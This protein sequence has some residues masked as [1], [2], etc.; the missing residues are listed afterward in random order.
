MDRLTSASADSPGS[1]YSF[2][3]FRL[4][5]DGR[6]LRGETPVDL[7]PKELAALR[8]LL[9]HAGQIVTYS[10]LRKA[11]W[12]DTHVAADTISECVTSLCARLQP[13]ECI[14]T[15]YKRGY[16]FS[17]AVWPHS[18]GLSGALPRLAIMPFATEFDAP[19]YLGAAVAE[20]TAARLNEAQPPIASVAAQDS[21]STLARRG[22][23]A[24]QIGQ[25]LD[26]DLVLTGSLRP[27]P[28][29]YRL[30][31]ET[32]RAR[33]GVQ[34]WLEDLFVER[35]RVAGLEEE[36]ASSLA[37]HLLHRGL[38]ISAAGAAPAGNH[39]NTPYQRQA[40]ELYQRAHSEWQTS[41]RHQMQDALQRLTRAIE[42]DP[43][44]IA[45]RVDLAH[46][47]ITQA[48]CG[49]MAPSIAA[50][51]VRRTA[52]PG[53][54]AAGF[55]RRGE[56]PAATAGAS[57][58]WDRRSI[59]DLALR[60]EAIL[61]ALGWI[62]FHVDRDLSAALQAFSLSTHLAHNP[63]TTRART[64]FSLSRHRFGEAIEALNAAIHLDPYS[65]WLQ[66]RLGW[67]LHLAG[68]PAA[69][70]QQIERVLTLFP[71]QENAG[72]YGSLILAYNGDAVRG[73]QLARELSQRC[74]SL[75]LA[76][77]A[78]AYA[79]ACAGHGD[80]ARSMLQRLEWLSRE[81]FVLN[82]F[83]AGTYVVL[84]ERDAALA[85]LRRSNE[86]RCP[87]FFQMLADPRL[88]PLRE[89]PEFARMKAIL[90]G[91]EAEAAQDSEW[92]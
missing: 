66:A 63:W 16:R 30:R 3:V 91:M 17:A 79:L 40:Y 31:A 18:A 37:F 56:G 49:F 22:L 24:Q 54:P 70:M 76:T 61:P 78:Y 44:L 15:V 62:T 29:H 53:P 11:L 20:Q 4:Q 42:L 88:Q 46:L 67:A 25:A 52:D 39:A 84:G 73:V 5:A 59:S 83:A 7:P 86:A 34:L 21:V 12:G 51:I 35:S 65:A 89:D 50:D 43:S 47:C 14:Q 13:E 6:L 74:P 38:S 10:Q 33:D 71:E 26:A 8:L 28:A 41:E 68:E 48:F 90:A 27:L 81:R 32:I 36:L 92:E 55:S 85:E 77:A 64:M 1:G 80:E 9:T 45:A 87:W 72:L 58:S 2:G 75:D 60:N 82:A 57:G 19:E 23:S 69:S